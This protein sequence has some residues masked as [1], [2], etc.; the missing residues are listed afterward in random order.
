M[1]REFLE[2]VRGFL[3]FIVYNINVDVIVYLNGEIV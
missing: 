1:V 3:M 2:K